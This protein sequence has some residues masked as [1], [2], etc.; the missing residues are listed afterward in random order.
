MNELNWVKKLN[1]SY[2]KEIAISDPYTQFSTTLKSG[3][4]NHMKTI[5][6]HKGVLEAGPTHIDDF[7]NF[8]FPKHEFDAMM[9]SYPNSPISS[10]A[11]AAVG[12]HGQEFVDHVAEKE[13]IDLSDDS[14][15]S[16]DSGEY[17]K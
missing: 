10:I 2:L 7:V 11:H 15:Q 1:E 3:I 4:L 8:H 17:Q 14:E 16:D 12:L 6:N 13:N 9:K 5:T